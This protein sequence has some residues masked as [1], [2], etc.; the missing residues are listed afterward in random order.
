MTADP[1]PPF[2]PGDRVRFTAD[3]GVSPAGITGVGHV[4]SVERYRRAG[5]G[6]LVDPPRWRYV[7]RVHGAGIGL[8]YIDFTTD[9]VGAP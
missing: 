2:V 1:Q 6:L 3:L 5:D 8:E 9:D 7:V 4:H